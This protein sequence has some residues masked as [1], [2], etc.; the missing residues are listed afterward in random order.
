M[1]DTPIALIVN[2]VARESRAE[3]LVELLDGEDFGAARIAT[4]VNGAFVP[5]AARVT[6]R[7]NDGDRIEIVSARQGG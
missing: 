5:A 6:T 7:L 3:T 1:R 2:G 4:A